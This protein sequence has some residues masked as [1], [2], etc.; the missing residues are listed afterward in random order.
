MGM[1]YKARNE[2]NQSLEYYN[3]ALHIS[4]LLGDLYGK[5]ILLNN[6]GRVYDEYKDYERA[7]EKYNESVQ[8]A[9]Q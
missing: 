3:E 6:I 2:H 9:E 8:I 5:I 4:D 7:L 1:I